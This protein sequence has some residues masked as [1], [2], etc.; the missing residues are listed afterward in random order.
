MMIPTTSTSLFQPKVLR[1]TTTSSFGSSSDATLFSSSSNNQSEEYSTTAP[2]T[3]TTGPRTGKVTM[4]RRTT[5][6]NNKFFPKVNGGRTYT[7]G[8]NN[9]NNYNNNINMDRPS[10][11][12]STSSFED[13]DLDAA[14]D[15]VLTPPNTA[16]R[17]TPDVAYNPVRFDDGFVILL[18]MILYCDTRR[19]SSIKKRKIYWFI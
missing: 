14:L 15:N 7:T 13:D 16:T 11:A 8:R 4:P 6:P 12:F 10:Q 5:N 3:I 1:S 18:A 9:N 17:N 19:V 2:Q